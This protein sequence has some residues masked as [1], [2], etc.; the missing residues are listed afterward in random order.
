MP[1][2]LDPVDREIV[3]ALQE[4]GRMSNVEIARRVGISEA[5]VRKRLDRLTTDSVIRITAVPDA[6]KVGLPTITFLALDVDLSQLDHVANQL[7]RLPEVRAIHYT[8]GDSD[9][10]M[11]AWFPSSDDL[12]HFLTRQIGSIPGIR[13]TATLHVLRTI[14]DSSTW[15]LPPTTPPRVLV[16]DDDPDFVEIVRLALTAEGLEV[17]AASSG[18]DALASMRVSKPELVILDVMMQGILDG[19]RT[20]TEIRADSDLR[21]MPILMVSSITGSEFAKLFP[22][23]ESLPV[24]NFFAK[25]VE[26]SQLVA[27]VK[28]FVRP[29]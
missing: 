21:M 14:K 20:V 24:D 11:E 22:G 16:V 19:L 18:E 4:D 2:S 9:L 5:T 12:L 10:I 7:A 29:R 6:A 27:E 1:H 25:P 15:T 28:R 23:E 17:S 8:S 26:I 13:R 3:R